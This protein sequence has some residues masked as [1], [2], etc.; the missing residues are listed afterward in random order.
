M[1]KVIPRIP[2]SILEISAS[3]TATFPET[4]SH[5][6]ERIAVPNPF[7]HAQPLFPYHTRVLTLPFVSLRRHSAAGRGAELIKLDPSPAAVQTFH[8]PAQGLLPRTTGTAETL[9][10][11]H[12]PPSPCMTHRAQVT[13][14]KVEVV[15]LRG[16]QRVHGLGFHQG[17]GTLW[18][19]TS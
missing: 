2:T 6:K 17:R 10:G 16:C 8:H 7:P 3:R 4:I 19:I 5:R 15:E 9:Q 13:S 18:C 1:E 11:T 14:T 12:L